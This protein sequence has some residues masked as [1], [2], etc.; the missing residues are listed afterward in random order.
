[1]YCLAIFSGDPAES[2]MFMG[3]DFDLILCKASAEVINRR[4]PL[5]AP[6]FETCLRNSAPSLKSGSGTIASGFKGLGTS[7]L[8]TL[9]LILGEV[10]NHSSLKKTGT[11]L[12]RHKE[13]NKAYLNHRVGRHDGQH[14]GNRKEADVLQLT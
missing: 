14:T 7:C 1:M 2:G 3:L 8:P 12:T 10:L 4:G 6:Y 9:T 11:D 5:T 13:K